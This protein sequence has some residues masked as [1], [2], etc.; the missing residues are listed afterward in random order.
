MNE[1]ELTRI[2]DL[3]EDVCARENCRLY[4][5]EF[6][7]QG[8]QRALRVFIDKPGVAEGVSL[9]DCAN[10][11]NGLS[12]QL[13]VEDLIPGDEYNLEVSSPGLERRLSSS[14]HYQ[15]LEQKKINL[16]LKKSLADV[17]KAGESADAEEAPAKHWSKCRK[18]AAQIEEVGDEKVYL[19]VDDVKVGVPFT[20]IEKANLVVEIEMAK[21]PKVNSGGKRQKQKQKKRK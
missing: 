4:E 15:G 7:G 6:V 21:K 17:W 14:W 3:A 16:R 1:S 2:R 12:L 5:L 13:D 19:L 10:V 11:S 20:D 9:D 18:L 8:K